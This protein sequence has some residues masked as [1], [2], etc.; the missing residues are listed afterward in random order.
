[1]HI[2]LIDD[3]PRDRDFLSNILNSNQLSIAVD[4]RE[5]LT[6]CQD[7]EKPYVISDIQM[8][9]LNGLEFARQLWQQQ[10]L[11]RIIFWS[12]YKDEQYVRAL[13]NLIPA[14][15]VYGYVLKNNTA[16][17]ILKAVSTVFEDY[18]CWVD[19][20]IRP[21]Q[22]RA[23]QSD[24]QI[25]DIEYESLIDIALGLTDNMIA[26]R[27]YLSRR[28]IQNRLRSL[29][30]K[31]GVDTLNINNDTF[32]L[33]TRAICIAMQRGLINPDIITHE[34]EKL[35]AWLSKDNH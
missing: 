24:S 16:D 22:A 11:A 18:Q 25:T 32:N 1:M 30:C 8:P 23:T 20:Y 13:S 2:L 10:P 4:G 12:Q 6:L 28:G 19:P 27:R 31:L 7:I 35:T 21:V 5:A 9:E 29:Y 15:T 3:N 14:D 26:K 33:R 34:E 17:V